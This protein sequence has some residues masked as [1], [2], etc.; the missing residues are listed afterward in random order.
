MAEE[1]LVSADP[2]G[3]GEEGPGDQGPGGEGPGGEGPVA[4]VGD[5]VLERRTG[6]YES[7]RMGLNT[8][9]EPLLGAGSTPRMWHMRG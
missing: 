5:G 2:D 9:R 6:W 4:I 1:G 7:F 3:P 8:S